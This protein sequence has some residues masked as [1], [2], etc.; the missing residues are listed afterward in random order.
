MKP[1]SI[2]K[3]DRAVIQLRGALTIGRPVE[4]LR[5]ALASAISRGIRRISLDLR[6]VPWADASGLG[7][8]VECRRKARE[9]GVALMLQGVHGKLEELLRMTRL[10][11]GDGPRPGSLTGGTLGGLRTPRPSR[12]AALRYRVA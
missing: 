10:E 3:A 7:A 4:A 1:N 11:D 9:A 8:L 2:E 12:A 6:R 5:L